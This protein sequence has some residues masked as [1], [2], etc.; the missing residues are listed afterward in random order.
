MT[1]VVSGHPL[2]AAVL[3]TLYV[4]LMNVAAFNVASAQSADEDGPRGRTGGLEGVLEGVSEGV[5]EGCDESRCL[6][7][8]N[9]NDS[10]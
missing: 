4:I 2:E 6:S 9:K 8:Q 5:L 10:E 7:C 1:P 3:L